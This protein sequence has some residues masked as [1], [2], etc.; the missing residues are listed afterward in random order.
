MVG[1]T[2]QKLFPV[3]VRYAD[4]EKEKI[5]TEILSVDVLDSS[6]ATGHDIYSHIKKEVDSVGLDLA[7]CISF[8]ADNAAVMVIMSVI[9]S[10]L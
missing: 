8:S 2:Q 5:V 9:M 3:L 1:M 4:M 10:C 7:N 6:T